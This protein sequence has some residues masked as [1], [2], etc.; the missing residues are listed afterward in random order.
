[1]PNPTPAA[2]LTKELTLLSEITNLPMSGDKC[3]NYM[4]DHWKLE[5]AVLIRAFARQ[6]VEAFRE[7]VAQVAQS[8]PYFHEVLAA[9][10]R[11]LEP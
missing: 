5:A 2:E 8:K 6:R 3:E 11:A 7:R 10:L 4:C 1:M 9:A